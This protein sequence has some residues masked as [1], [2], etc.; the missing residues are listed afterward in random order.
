M[1]RKQLLFLS[2]L[3]LVCA[4]PAADSL[5]RDP[6]GR[7]TLTIDSGWTPTADAGGVQFMRGQAFVT[8]LV[9]DRP[10]S[11][12]NMASSIMQTVSRQWQKFQAFDP[13]PVTFAGQTGVF[14][15]A[16]GVNPK[17]VASFFACY[18]AENNGTGFLMLQSG[19]VEEMKTL[20]AE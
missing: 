5:Y 20:D 9:M 11:A 16:R 2:T 15:L 14:A 13:E 19:P 18:A 7:F 6:Q 1:L 3:V 12:Q 4:P 8:V 10:S 17:G